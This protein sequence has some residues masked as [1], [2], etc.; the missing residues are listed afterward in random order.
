[1]ATAFA[2]HRLVGNTLLVFYE[3]DNTVMAAAS[4]DVTVC[5]PSSKSRDPHSLISRYLKL[6]NRIGE[7]KFHCLGA[8]IRKE[9]LRNQD[10]QILS[11]SLLKVCYFFEYYG[12]FQR[13]ECLPV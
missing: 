6:L 7:G 1:M 8:E 10:L 12:R 11:V 3:D 4:S 5:L 9:V 13:N 2:N